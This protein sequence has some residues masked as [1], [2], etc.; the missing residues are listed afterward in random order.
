MFIAILP[1]GDMAIRPY[2]G[3][4]RPVAFF[5]VYFSENPLYMQKVVATLHIGTKTHKK[6]LGTS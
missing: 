2:F 3:H 6:N 5:P 4:I 1:Y